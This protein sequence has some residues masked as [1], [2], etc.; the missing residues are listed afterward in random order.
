MSG[1]GSDV[2]MIIRE[3]QWQNQKTSGSPR[4]VGRMLVVTKG[5]E[6]D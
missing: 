5:Y 2:G 1:A 4:S 3:V 6:G